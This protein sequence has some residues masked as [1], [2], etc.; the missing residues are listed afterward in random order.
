MKRSDQLPVVKREGSCHRGKATRDDNSMGRVVNGAQTAPQSSRH[1]HDAPLLHSYTGKHRRSF[2]VSRGATRE[3]ARSFTHR[4]CHCPC[5]S[6][7]LH[8]APRGSPESESLSRL[9][10]V[11]AAMD[12]T[13]PSRAEQSLSSGTSGGGGCAVTPIDRL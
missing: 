6:V 12:A 13:P 7:R 4:C 1:S 9:W 5:G 2:L 8:A 11:G 10:L 3:S